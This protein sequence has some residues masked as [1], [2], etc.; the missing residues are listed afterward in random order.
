[1]KTTTRPAFLITPEELEQS[2]KA[3]MADI[4]D[5]IAA[6]RINLQNVKLDRR[7]K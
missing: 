3:R 6:Q 1:M 7:G 2:I 4:E 5:A